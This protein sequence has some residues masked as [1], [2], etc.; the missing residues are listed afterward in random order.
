VP[1]RLPLGLGRDAQR[2]R[3]LLL[4][5]QLVPQIRDHADPEGRREGCRA[6][7][8]LE[9]SNSR[10]YEEQRPPPP[11]TVNEPLRKRRTAAQGG[12]DKARAGVRDQAQNSAT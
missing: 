2:Q 12:T 5:N 1:S 4:V 10:G 6:P 11:R 7:G 8:A 9:E 3:M